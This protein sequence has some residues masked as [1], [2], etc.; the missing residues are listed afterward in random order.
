MFRH[1]YVCRYVHS[2]YKQNR[3]PLSMTH[4]DATVGPNSGL[5]AE[6]GSWD[7]VLTDEILKTECDLQEL[8]VNNN[9][10][11]T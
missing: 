3:K 4:H 11:L 2:K 5:D 7:D 8:P 1:V 10:L 9:Q 6:A